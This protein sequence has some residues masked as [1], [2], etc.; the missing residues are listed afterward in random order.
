MPFS[1]KCR[2]FN[3]PESSDDLRWHSG[4]TVDV[5]DDAANISD[6]AADVSDDVA[7]VSDDTADVSDGVYCSDAEDLHFTEVLRRQR[8][9]SKEV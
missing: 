7:D 9:Q 8:F 3:T 1:L 2:R 6:D 5:S 4:D